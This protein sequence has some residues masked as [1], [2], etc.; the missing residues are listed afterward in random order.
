MARYGLS[1]RHSIY[2]GRWPSTDLA[3]DTVSILVDG[4]VLL[5]LLT[6]VVIDASTD[7][8]IW[9]STDLATDTVSIL[10]DGPVLLTLLTRFVEV[11]STDAD[12]GP[13]T[14]LAIDVAIALGLDST[15][16]LLQKSNHW[17]CGCLQTSLGMLLP[18]LDT[19]NGFN[20]ASDK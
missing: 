15:D 3:T 12:I 10:V 2:P 11:A 16:T 5:T 1:H 17:C 7:A 8:D 18:P 20:F 6:R 14:D 19:S 13:S 4:P 9:P